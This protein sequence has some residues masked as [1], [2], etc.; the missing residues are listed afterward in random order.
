MFLFFY[1]GMFGCYP[2][3]YDSDDSYYSDEDDDDDDEVDDE[4]LQ[5]IA[6]RLRKKYERKVTEKDTGM[7]VRLFSSESEERDF[8]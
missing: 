8:V 1:V 2:S 5:S 7:Q 6:R 4:V 3:M